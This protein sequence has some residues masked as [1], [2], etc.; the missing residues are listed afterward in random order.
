MSARPSCSY[1]AMV[2]RSLA[3]AT[4]LV[5]TAPARADRQ[6]SLADAIALARGRRAELGQAEL[7]IRRAQLNTLRAKL[8]RAHLTLQANVVEQAQIYRSTQN[9]A[10]VVCGLSATD[11]ATRCPIE[12]HPYALTAD[13]SVPV[14]SGLTVEAHV[15]GARASERAA[16]ANRRAALNSIGLDAANAYWEV[17]RA[18]LALEVAKRALDR[19]QAIER[20]AKTRVSAG[21][22]PQVD[23]ERA[24]VSS[25]RQ[26]ETVNAIE[27]NELVARAQLGAALQLDE[28]VTLGE[29]PA[30]HAPPLPPLPAA[31]DA[32]AQQRPELAAT[33]AVV[34]AQ[35]QTVRAAKGAY[36]PQVSLFGQATAGNQDF[37]GTRSEERRVG[38]ECTG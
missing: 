1:G 6:L 33:R 31:L 35:I 11:S 22:A 15:A 8:E 20:A 32:A 36:W 7:D 12:G 23:Y 34:D 2:R 4:L 26:A 19:T 21:I 30:A 27:S 13:L 25:M 37:F 9:S 38:K 14:W 10:Q 28:A 3:F 18:E 29:D 16:D 17:R 24:H 5:L